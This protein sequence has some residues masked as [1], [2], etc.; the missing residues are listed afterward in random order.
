V[1]SIPAIIVLVCL[2]T[3]SLLSGQAPATTPPQSIEKQPIFIR[4]EASGASGAR[5]VSSSQ[6]GPDYVRVALALG[7]VIGLVL[8]LRWIG[9]R[10]FPGSVAHKGS[11]VVQVISRT[12]LGPKQSVMLM[13]VGRRVLVVADSG[14]SMNSLCEIKSEEEV[15]ELVGQ[16]ASDKK[17]SISRTFGQLFGRTK[18]KFVTDV[19]E[20]SPPE[21]EEAEHEAE[22]DENVAATRDELAGLSQKVKLLSKRF[23]GT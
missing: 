8:F 11:G 5:N 6:G 7:L 22:P 10:L 1:K 2:A 3:A 18:E 12:M 4:G 19:E 17:D 9:G 16:A 14:A 21:A 15:A 20:N 23:G 13:R